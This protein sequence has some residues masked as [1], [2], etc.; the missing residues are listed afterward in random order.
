MAAKGS[1]AVFDL[2]HVNGRSAMLPVQRVESSVKSNSTEDCSRLDAFRNGDPPSDMKGGPS[3]AETDR[4][5]R[6]K[7]PAV[8]NGIKR[9]ITPSPSAFAPPSKKTATAP[10]GQSAPPL[11]GVPIY[12]PL[13]ASRPRV[14][15]RAPAPS[16]WAAACHPLVDQVSQEVDGWFLAH[17]PFASEKARRKFVAAGFSR[18]T[19]LYYPLAKDERIHFACRLLTILFLIDGVYAVSD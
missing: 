9:R 13:F 14:P 5:P 4:L 2:G 3:A 12:A 8:A 15:V 16:P 17:W 7:T 18:V 1:V 19:C 6:G 11:P 10:N